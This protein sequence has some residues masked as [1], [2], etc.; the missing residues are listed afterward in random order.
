MKVIPSARVSSDR[1][2]AIVRTGLLSRH[3]YP[4]LAEVTFQVSSRFPR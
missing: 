2:V 1:Q 4:N 3:E